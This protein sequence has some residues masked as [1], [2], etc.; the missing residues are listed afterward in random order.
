MTRNTRLRVWR[1]CAAAYAKWTSAA[2][3]QM[4][5]AR[6]QVILGRFWFDL[7][8][9]SEAGV[10]SGRAAP[11]GSSHKLLLRCFRRRLSSTGLWLEPCRCHVTLWPN[12]CTTERKAFSFGA[13]TLEDEA[14]CSCCVLFR[15]KQNKEVRAL[16]SCCE[17]ERLSSVDYSKSGA[18]CVK[19][20]GFSFW[21]W[22]KR[23]RLGGQYTVAL[24]A[25]DDTLE[26]NL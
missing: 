12:S 7:C 14:G 9:A 4:W 24:K 26:A 17:M 5:S 25:H 21:A 1:C 16:L 22:Q 13:N 8:R 10:P 23:H 6:S 19:R 2:R 15:L 18:S 20:P 11:P 3:R